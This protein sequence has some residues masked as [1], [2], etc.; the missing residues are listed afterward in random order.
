MDDSTGSSTICHQIIFKFTVAG[1]KCLC[2]GCKSR[3]VLHHSTVFF[4]LSSGPLGSCTLFNMT[5]DGIPLKAL[6]GGV[7]GVA[8]FSTTNELP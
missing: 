8:L 7:S 4:F 1:V 6:L 5:E 2:D 3:P